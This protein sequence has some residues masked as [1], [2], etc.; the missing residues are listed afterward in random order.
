MKN[1]LFKQRVKYNMLVLIFL[2]FLELMRKQLSFLD[3]TC[4]QGWTGGSRPQ[5]LGD[6]PRGSHDAVP[7]PHPSF[8]VG[9]TDQPYP[10][11]PGLTGID[12]QQNACD[13]RCIVGCEVKS[14]GRHPGDV[15]TFISTS[16]FTLKIWRRMSPCGKASVWLSASGGRDALGHSWP[17][18]EGGRTASLPGMP[19]R[20]LQLPH[21][22]AP[23][24]LHTPSYTL[25]LSSFSSQASAC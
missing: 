7:P 24:H 1:T 13:P 8:T 20:P 5:R 10:L 22:K 2:L 6:V 21:H 19:C 15:I 23:P 4:T 12:G 11:S 9:T 25:Y 16:V 14:Q 18:C 3:L 17:K